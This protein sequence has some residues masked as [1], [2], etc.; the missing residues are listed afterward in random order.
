[1]FLQPL[2]PRSTKVPVAFTFRTTTAAT[3]RYVDLSKIRYYPKLSCIVYYSLQKRRCQ[4]SS[5]KIH[6]LKYVFPV[7]VLVSTM[8]HLPISATATASSGP[9][10]TAHPALLHIHVPK[11]SFGRYSECCGPSLGHD[12]KHEEKDSK[13]LGGIKYW[14]QTDLLCESLVMSLVR[15]FKLR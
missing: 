5:P 9:A 7:M 8:S 11:R 10:L 4:P 13:Y 3:S 15:T 12:K 14:R 6:C 2:C 1:M